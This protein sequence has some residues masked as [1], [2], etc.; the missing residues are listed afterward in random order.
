MPARSGMLIPMP[1][2]SRTTGI[3]GRRSEKKGKRM[4]DLFRG[5]TLAFKMGVR[6]PRAKRD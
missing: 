4:A 5:L 3:T 2:E 1:P 6:G